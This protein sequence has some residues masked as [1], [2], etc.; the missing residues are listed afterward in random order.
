MTMFIEF[1]AFA[2]LTCVVVRRLNHLL[3]IL[4]LSLVTYIYS[5]F[6]LSVQ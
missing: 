1:S 3:F 4:I 2:P 6:Y 5:L